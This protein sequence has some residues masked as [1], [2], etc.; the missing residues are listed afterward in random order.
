M[1]HN[2]L[3]HLFTALLLMCVAVATA[4]DFCVDGVYYRITDATNKMVAVTYPSSGYSYGQKQIII[5]ENVTYGTATYRVTKIDA[6]A[7]RNQCQSVT[8]PNSITNIGTEAIRC[9]KAFWLTNTPP[10]GYKN[11]KATINYVSNEEYS[12]LNNVNVYPFLSSK[13]EVDGVIYV[14]ISISER[15]C[16]VVDSSYDTVYPDLVIDKTVSYKGVM[17]NVKDIQPYTF[18]GNESIINLKVCNSGIIGKY[19]FS[20]SNIRTIIIDEGVT[21]IHEHAFSGCSKLENVVISNSVLDIGESVFHSCYNLTSISIGNGLTFIPGST[22]KECTSLKDVRIEDGESALHLEYSTKE[23]ESGIGGGLF[24]FAPLKNLYIGRNLS[25]E[26][27][28]SYGYSPFYNIS[29]LTSVTIGNNVTSISNSAFKGCSNLKSIDIPNSVTS[30]EP[31][32]FEDCLNLLTVKIPDSV[33][34]IGN[35]AFSGC[36]S[37]TSIIIPNNLISIGGGAFYGCLKIEEIVIPDAVIEIGPSAFQNCESLIYAKIGSGIEI[38]EQK[39]FRDCKA[40]DSIT[41]GHNVKKIGAGAFYNCSSLKEIVIPKQVSMIQGDVFTGC[42]SLEN[43]IIN[44]RTTVLSLGSNGLYSLF[45]DSPLDSVYIGAKLNY[46]VSPFQNNI[47]LRTVFISDSETEI[48]EGEFKGC[49]NL[50]NVLIGDGVSKINKWAFSGCSNLDYFSFGNRVQYIGDEAFS[51]CNNVTKIITSVI[52]PPVCGEQALDDINK[53]NCTL[54]VPEKSKTLYQSSEQWKD[55][56]FIEGTAT[57]KYT[58]TFIIDGEIYKTITVEYGE[59]I[60]LP[61]TP[62]KEGHTFSGWSEIPETMPAEDVVIEGIFDVNYYTITYIVDEEVY[63]TDSIAYGS[64]IVLREEPVKEG[65]TFSGWSKAPET[66]PAYDIAIE[67]CFI[68]DTAINEIEDKTIN[69]QNV[70]Y[71]LNGRVVKKATNGIY[72][73][74]G[75]KVLVK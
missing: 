19:A 32:A 31:K 68:I 54:F 15:T 5:P 48:Y 73:H 67:G 39:L 28:I 23:R 63:A 46:D 6:N 16:D 21:S 36:S 47:S 51:D 37:L 2:Y 9:N 14:P 13:F 58:I 64:K 72:I 69:V 17:M 44:D 61:E 75:K 27:G 70:Y 50:K 22:F 74:K 3:K 41:I 26:T 66:M 29:T 11:V 24:W 10:N 34:K 57:E 65:H 30:I 59:E 49:S 56:F 38:I 40:M 43:V 20:Y 62:T 33:T 71:D 45:K 12:L 4:H 25:Y 52:V 1:K 35:N 55:F 60:P 53:W 7:I 18:Y 8:I 42:S